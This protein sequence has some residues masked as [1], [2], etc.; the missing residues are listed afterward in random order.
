MDLK[1]SMRERHTVRKYTNLPLPSEIVK[2][3]DK[4]IDETNKRYELSME[5]KTED[6]RAFN[7]IIKLILAKGVKN[8]FYHGWKGYS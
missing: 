5:L 6:S 8:F 4:Y 1:E 2:L 3:L 7:T